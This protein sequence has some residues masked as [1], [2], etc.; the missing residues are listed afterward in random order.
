M[1]KQPQ[2]TRTAAQRPAPFLLEGLA[3]LLAVALCWLPAP[4]SAADGFTLFESGQVRP[5]AL[6][7]DTNRLFAVNTPDNALE[8]F[9]VTVGGLSHRAS[10]PV[11]L[12]PVAVA[13]RTNTEVWVVNHLSDSVSVVDLA[14][15]DRPFVRRTLLVG[16]EPR[17]IV[18]GGSAKDRAFITTAHRGQNSGINQEVDLITAGQGR[19][20]VWVFD[21]NALGTSLE[22]TPL[23]VVT[24]FGD[25]PRALAVTPDGST[26]YAAV[27]DSGNQTTTLSEGAV[28]DGGQGA[29]GLPFPNTNHAGIPGPE[30]GLI[31]QY[32]GSKWA[33]RLGRDWSSS[34]MF[35]LPDEDVFAIDADASPPVQSIVPGPTGAF[36]RVGTILFNMI[37]N[38][39]PANNRI[40][41]TNS[42]ARNE[43]RFEGAG[44]FLASFG[45]ET[46]R[47]RLHQYRITVLDPS[48]GSVTPH[49]LNSHIDYSHCCDATPN[50]VSEASLAT[51]LD[52]AITSD[53][54]TLFVAAFGSSKIGIFDTGQLEAGSFI[55]S[56]NDHIEVSGGGPSG[57]VL[58]E[59]RSRLYVLTR[60]DD[61]ISIISTGTGAESAHVAL[62]N[63]EPKSVVDGR[64][65]L[66]DARTTSGN[67][68]ASCSSCHVFGD[69][70]SLAWDLGDP[71][72]DVINNPGPFSVPTEIFLDPD[73]NPLKGPMTTQSL[74]GMDNHGPMHWR[75][76]RTGGNDSAFEVQPNHGTFDEDAAFKKFNVAFPGLLGRDK[77][78]KSDEIQKFADFILQ[79]MYPPN[80]V[81]A[82]DDSLT[83]DQAAGR[84][85]YFGPV[86][87]SF[88]PCNGCHVLD[89]NGNAQYSF[90]KRPGFFGGDG[91]YSFENEPQ[92]FKV[93]HLRNMYQKV[94][95]FGMPAVSF[96]NPGN[97]GFQGDQ[98][99]GFGFLHDGSV[100][101]M[102]RFHNAKVFNQS[103]VNPTGI[104]AGA[105][106]DPIRRQL[107]QFM[108]AYD[109][110]LKP[111][112]GQQA[113]LTSTSGT[114][115]NDRIDLMIQRA[116]AGDCEVVV[117]GVMAGEERGAL[118]VG[119][120]NFETDRVSEGTV[121]DATLRAYAATAG[122]ELTYTAVPVGDGMRIGLDRD[123]DGFRDSD[124]IDA[125]SDPADPLDMPCT[126]TAA[127]AFKRA[128]FVDAKGKLVFK[129]EVVT[130]GY[131]QENLQLVSADGGGVILDSGVLGA[132]TEVNKSGTSYKYKAARDA[133]G[134]VR[135]TIKSNK[136]V[137]GGVKVTVKSKEAWAPPKADETPATT[138]VRLNVGGQCFEGNATRV[139]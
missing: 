22:G 8:I 43:R 109:S 44:N 91:R 132:D 19:A 24:L 92:V 113:T 53:G 77:E 131:A 63:P 103:G 55:P 119:G 10:V 45:A 65:F 21:A 97:N 124:E 35:S 40:Y 117:K 99:R 5:L 1:T 133:T 33:D 120:N 58:D 90:V 42:E 56:P 137:P 68:E 54:S 18:F 125:G 93:P 6:S 105:P 74:R 46:V 73:F 3:M 84:A 104:P 78:L 34:V 107:E 50:V 4:A 95:M 139:K 136:K 57:L 38:P 102:F 29:G 41:V 39:N 79:V 28:P 85:F 7:P 51:P 134:I 101:T 32:D 129:A 128:V 9:D 36:A 16:D 121:A 123:G 31:V 66:Y 67:G 112:V 72:G 60:F 96:F 82:L 88:Q 127:T 12:E 37:V 126:T 2:P 89:P 25:T 130:G 118:Y 59:S 114:D 70:D 69:F 86:S 23:T 49:H 11:G 20:D 106:G 15:P 64:R 80:P 75:G 52:M 30:T 71:D 138:T 111:I 48:D 27:F 13:A 94:G 100:D 110:N 76:D 116:D 26:V 17:D 81:R 108:L 122:Q 98:I 14:D 115:T 47:G 83:P 62:H 87:D 61:S 135:V